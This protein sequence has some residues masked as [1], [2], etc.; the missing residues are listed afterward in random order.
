MNQ[1]APESY[2][3][4]VRLTF[5]AGGRTRSGQIVYVALSIACAVGCAAA[6]V[7][8]DLRDS[9]RL[10]L[11]AAAIAFVVSAI[12][13]FASIRWMDSHGGWLNR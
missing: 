3:W 11:G 7:I 12:W 6:F 5:F 10:L 8:F 2:P 9:T 1:P 4:W 13:Y